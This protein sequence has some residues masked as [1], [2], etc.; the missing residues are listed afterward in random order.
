MW[1]TYVLVDD[2]EHDRMHPLLNFCNFD[3]A[4]GECFLSLVFVVARVVVTDNSSVRTDT[5]STSNSC[6]LSFGGGQ[7][8]RSCSTSKRIYAD[9]LISCAKL[10]YG[11]VCYSTRPWLTKHHTTCK[12]WME[13]RPRD[14][15]ISVQP[16]VNKGE[17]VV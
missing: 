15:V 3:F 8:G 6:K 1:L 10:K 17:R 16:N 7:K 13:S 2:D 5:G 12:S 9:F 4:G 11:D 14:T